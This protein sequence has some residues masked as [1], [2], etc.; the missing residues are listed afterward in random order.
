MGDG[1]M[2][3]IGAML[4]F[5][6]SVLNATFNSAFI[7]VVVMLVMQMPIVNV[8]QMVVM[9]NCSMS[10]IGAMDMRMFVLHERIMA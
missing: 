3:A 8:I 9:R 7:P 5:V 1:D 10:A 2:T 4:V 6:L